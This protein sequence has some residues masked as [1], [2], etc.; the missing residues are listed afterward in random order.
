[1]NEVYE[2]KN[3]ISLLAS[4]KIPNDFNFGSIVIKKSSASFWVCIE[5]D[6]KV[7]SDSLLDILRY[8]IESKLACK[9]TFDSIGKEMSL[10][11]IETTINSDRF[12]NSDIRSILKKI[13]EINSDS[14]IKKASKQK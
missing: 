1:M 11:R 8:A 9:M 14:T 7:D 3:I 6:F 5:I 4:Q 13:D 10:V 2:I 12:L